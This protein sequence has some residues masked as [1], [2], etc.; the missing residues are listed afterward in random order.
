VREA[1][2]RL[3]GS[4]YDSLGSLFARV[5]REREAGKGDPVD[6]YLI[7]LSAR[8]V[9]REVGK[10]HPDFWKE[11]RAGVES[12]EQAL[13]FARV[14]RD[15]LGAQGGPDMPAFLDWFDDKFLARARPVE[16]QEGPA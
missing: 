14:I 11:H 16:K 4:K 6:Q 7:T 10:T 5:A 9:L 2:Y 12:L 8:Q 15:E 3:F 13:R 1:T